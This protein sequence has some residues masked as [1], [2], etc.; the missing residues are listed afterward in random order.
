MTAVSERS[1]GSVET[2]T[3]PV[4]RIWRLLS[5]K[6]FSGIYLFVIVIIAYSMLTP[7]FLT[8]TTVRTI[9]SQQ[10]I[11]AMLAIGLTVALAT[12]VFD[13]SIG[14][15]MGLSNI[16]V[17][18]LMVDAGMNPALAI[19]LTVL[20]AAIIGVV[21]GILVT[22]ARI[23][24]FIATL[25]MNSIL[26]AAIVVISGNQNI[27]GIP[28]TFQQIAVNQLWSIPLPVFY[29]AAVGLLVA[30]VLQWTSVGRRLYA[31]GGSREVARLAGVRTDRYVIGAFVTS[32]TVA[33]LA[34]I[35]VV[36]TV[37]TGS[38]SVGQSYLLPAFAAGFLGA[39]QFFPGRF[40]VWGTVLAVYLLATGVKGLVLLGAQPWVTDLFNGVA[41]IA[42]VGLSGLQLVRRRRKSTH[43]AGEHSIQAAK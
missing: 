43:I 41:L 32:A 18:R 10:A 9:A 28:E 36:A 19:V 29:M 34:G 3:R 25:G 14:G 26:L 2:D 30:Y 21:N 42:A 15:V 17:A 6:K 37:G 12:G 20:V 22:R 8:S 33:A 4:S 40:N 5:P 11:T 24:P 27:L 31:T 1:P 23:D 35:L 16:V 7:T 13:L 38:T 39:T